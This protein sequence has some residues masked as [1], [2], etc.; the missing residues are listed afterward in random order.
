MPT[1]SL[2]AEADWR[3]IS[4]GTGDS[5]RLIGYFEAD[6]LISRGFSLKLTHDWIDPDLDIETDAQTRTSIGIE[7]IPIPF[8]QLRYFVRFR[9]GPPQTLGARDNSVEIEAHFFF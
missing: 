7:S 4:S 9:D 1:L 6:V 5:R 8:L 2:L 3:E